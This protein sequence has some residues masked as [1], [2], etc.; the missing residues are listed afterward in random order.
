MQFNFGDIWAHIRM[1]DN[2]EGW[3]LQDVLLATTLTSFPASAL[4]P[5]ST[6]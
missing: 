5:T 1:A 4:T 6:P 2:V 3:V